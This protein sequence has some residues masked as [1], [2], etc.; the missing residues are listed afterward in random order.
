MVA[1]AAEVV[2]AEEEGD[3]TMDHRARFVKWENLCT[4]VKENW[5][6]NLQIPTFHIS[7][8]VYIFK[9]ERV[10]W[11]SEPC[12]VMISHI[13]LFLSFLYLTTAIQMLKYICY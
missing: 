13:I 12:H 4:D 5:F 2:G 9:M 8:L 11:V 6:A 3:S 7:M 10:K 1:A